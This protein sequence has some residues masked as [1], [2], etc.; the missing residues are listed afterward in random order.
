MLL[1]LGMHRSGT[2]VTTRLLECLGAVHSK[3][4][5]PPMPNNPKGFFEDLD[6]ERFNEYKF[7]PRIGTHWHSIGF[8]DW[9]NL[10]ASDRSKFALEALEIVRSNYTSFNSLSVLKE[11]RIGILLPFWLS[12]LHHAGYN[13]KVVCALRDPASVAR[14]LTARDGFS[15]THG[16]M[17]YITNWLSILSYIQ[18]L[19]VAFVQFDEIFSDPARVLRTVADKLT[20]PLPADFESRLHGFSSSFFDSS[21]RHSSLDRRDLPLEADLPPLAI[22]LYEN[23]LSAA[24]AQNIKKTA[25][26]VAAAEKIVAPLKPVFCAF[27]KVFTELAGSRHATM[28]SQSESQK[29]QNAL[30]DAQSAPSESRFL[31]EKEAMMRGQLAERLT[32][33]DAEKQ[34]LGMELEAERKQKGELEAQVGTLAA[35]RSTLLAERD[36][37]AT[38]RD[39]LAADKT[40]LAARLST[41]DSEHASLVAERDDLATR[42]QQLTAER[43][44]LAERLTAMDAE[45]QKLS[46]D[47]EGARKQNSDLETQSSALAA[48]LSSL[49]ARLST[50]LAERDGLATERDI[51][52]ADKTALAARLSTLD[53]E[54]ASLSTRHQQLATEREALSAERGQFA[55]RLTAMDAEKQGLG[56]ELEGARQQKGDLEAQVG[57]LA[58]ER[59]SLDARLSTL[60][61][62][63]AALVAERDSLASERSTLDARLSTLSTLSSEHSSLVTSHSSLVAERDELV[64]EREAL[65]VRVS[66]LEA[67]LQE[68]FEELAK[69]AK[70]QISTEDERNALQSNVSELQAERDSLAAE[71]STLDA[72]LAVLDAEHSSLATRHQQLATE[73]EALSTDLSQRFE[74]IALLGKRLLE[75]EAEG[76]RRVAAIQARMDAIQA[77]LT[78]KLGAPFRATWDKTRNSALK[79]YRLPTTWRILRLHRSSGLFNHEWYLRQNPDVKATTTRPFLHFAFH[80]VFEGRSP[81]PAYSESAYIRNTPSA[82][83]SSLKPLLHYTLKGWKG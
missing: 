51:L 70:L 34:G 53:S 76:D 59:S 50:L 26:F 74:E 56:V 80:G 40:T 38:E 8:V 18:D 72:R 27:D 32:A 2:S 58:A 4:L 10:S 7:L 19:P 42:H 71:R 69:L 31:L 36:G 25:K 64:T 75:V 28:A 30:R 81:N 3:N 63:H 44:Q 20:I 83:S 65:S 39:I 78:W 77:R 12:V 13:V 68:R 1:V 29:L 22:E 11:P 16:G 5:H 55:E 49:A 33:M 54:H 43:G 41:L 15:T 6:I 66:S 67:D 46:A 60:S 73:R 23:L 62:E 24:Q 35:E 14:S 48:E 61:F 9:T 79:I 17:L 45:K 37:L 47:L 21:L 82:Q 52:V 57:T